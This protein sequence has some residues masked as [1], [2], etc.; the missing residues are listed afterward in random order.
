MP[1]A[2]T[3]LETL[4]ITKLLQCV[5]DQDEEQ[6]EK[7]TT[8][9]VPHLI[10]YND[11]YDGDTAL[12]I[13]A[14]ANDDSMI[15]TLLKLGAHPDV[16]DFKGRSAVMRAAEYG[17]VQCLEKLVKWG[18]DMKLTDVEGKGRKIIDLMNEK[19][20]C[21][22]MNLYKFVTLSSN[23]LKYAVNEYMAYLP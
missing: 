20:I 10:N 6:I 9:G 16:V 15:S 19:Q 13:A 14:I 3:R 17:H 7:L 4:Q 18:A 22:P 1:V 11:P 8:H 23:S 5:R 21:R 12:N 2:Q